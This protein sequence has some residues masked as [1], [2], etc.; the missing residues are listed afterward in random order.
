MGLFRQPRA[1]DWQ[2]VREALAVVGLQDLAQR[3]ISQLSGGQQQ[4]MF[5][6]R[7]LAQ[8]A[9]LMLMDE[10]LTGLDTPSQEDIFQILDNLRTRHVTIMVA[11]HDLQLA[12][13][14]F[15]RVMLL[16]HRLIGLGS[17]EDVFA[18]PALMD[19]YGSHLRLLKVN[20]ETIAVEDTCCDDGTAHA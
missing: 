10:P 19:A 14:R 2:I 9:E 8:E 18:A 1:H 12:A 20:G 15:D 4:R 11:L 13:E 17:P 7:A 6:A 3:Q 16:N 5:I